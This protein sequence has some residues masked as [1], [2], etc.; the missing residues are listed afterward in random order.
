MKQVLLTTLRDRSTP[1][2]KYRQTAD[3]LAEII[4]AESGQFLPKKSS[5][6]TTPLDVAEGASLSHEPVLIPILRSG[7][8]LLP[9]FLRFY[10]R[11]PVGFLGIRREEKTAAP[12]LYYQNIPPLSP[13]T[14]VFILEPMIA[15]AGSAILAATILKHAGAEEKNITLVSVLAA[16]EGVDNFI[17][18]HPKVRHHIVHIDPKL[19][20]KKMIVPGLGDFGDRYFGT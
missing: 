3:L 6:V 8:T 1:I 2:E 11:S 20:L 17:E 14:P 19:D 10:P 15:T 16:R 4:A 12:Q 9:S 7:L 13:N 5:P 18:C